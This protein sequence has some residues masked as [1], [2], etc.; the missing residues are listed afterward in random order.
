M[1]IVGAG[2]INLPITLVAKRESGSL[3]RRR[4]T[5]VP[6]WVPIAADALTSIVP[7]P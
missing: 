4:A 1:A 3:K 5:P 6:S 2:L 7:A